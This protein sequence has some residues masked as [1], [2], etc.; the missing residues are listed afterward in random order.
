MPYRPHRPRFL[1]P[2][3]HPGIASGLA[4]RDK[5]GY[6]PYLTLKVSSPGE[7]K[8]IG[9]YYLMTAKIKPEALD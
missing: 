5:P 7:V 9:K 4:I 1:N 3:S 6:L 2:L 8:L